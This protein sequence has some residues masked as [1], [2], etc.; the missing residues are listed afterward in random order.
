MCSAR[1]SRV[2][3][4]SSAAILFAFVLPGLAAP[5][6]DRFETSVKPFLHEHCVM[7]HNAKLSSGGLNLDRFLS[8]T[9]AA[10]LSDREHWEMVVQK[11]KAGE[12]PPKG[13]PRPPADQITTVTDW[14]QTEYA[15]LDQAAKPEPGRVTAHRLNRAEYN[16]TIRDLLHVNLRV[17]DDFPVDPYGYGFDNIGDVLSL[18]PVLT[19]EYLKAAER[20]ARAAIPTGQPQKLIVARYLAER[21]GQAN[22]LHVQVVH[23]FPVD[24]EYTLRAAWFQ[25]YLPGF[26]M[27]G[28]LFLDGKQVL[29]KDITIYTEMDRGFEAP[30][31]QISQGPHKVEASIEIDPAWK[32]EK[33]YVEY[34][35][36]HG[37]TKQTP[38]ELTAPYQQ[39]FACGHAPG[40]HNPSCARKILEP[41][42]HRAFRRPVTAKELDDLLSLVK[43]AQK[44][45]DSFETGIRVALEAILMSPN[46]LFRIERNPPGT[47]AHHI[48][49]TELASR[50]SY[51]LWSSMPD[52]ELLKLA[53]QN[54]LHDPS[55][56]HKQVARMLADS[57]SEALVENFGGQWLKIRNLESLTPDP[58]KFPDFDDELRDDMLTE[59]QMFFSDII[60]EDR[61]VLDFLDG[62]YTYVNERLAKFYGIEGVT[63]PEFR[64]VELNGAERSGVITQASVLTVSSYPTRTS[65]V[66][67]GKWILET[68]LNTPP[69][70][71]PPDVPALNEEAIGVSVSFRQELEKHRTNPLCA[72]CH[73]RMDPLGF[74]LENYDA[75]GR[76][77][78]TDGKFPIDASGALPNG[79]TFNGPAEL[80]AILKSD[81]HGFVRSLTENLLTYALGRGLEPYDRPA[82]ESIVRSVEQNGDRFSQLVD[83]IVASVPFQMRSGAA[84]PGGD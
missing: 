51:F 80:K 12:M 72:S 42:A 64:R 3:W 50:L 70:P 2:Y 84:T 82:V 73:S 30:D 19:E 31:L 59:T 45:G 77:R 29:E 17:A 36:I 54:R 79:K 8:Q 58:V 26:K 71:P 37:P 6:P 14:V 56:L 11:L 41:L 48:T 21:M 40:H 60:K 16:N 25:G 43:M 52:D 27:K 20:V 23:E 44:R 67:R 68:I 22:R 5:A 18:S 55:V 75:I 10:A 83:S 62:R 66:I 13:M 9:A 1:A 49:D 53:E 78:T 63:G 39:I 35:Q 32:K 69:P 33:P 24:G 81:G 47:E 38:P 15:R 76:W 34:I 74:G 57:K 4:L 61:S 46:F 65:P 28:R 7:C